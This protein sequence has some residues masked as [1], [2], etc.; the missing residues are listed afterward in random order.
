MKNLQQIL[1]ILKSWESGYI[2]PSAQMAIKD[3]IELLIKQNNDINE[4][5]GIISDLD[6]KLEE[7]KKEVNLLKES[8][9]KPS[10]NKKVNNSGELN[11]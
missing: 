7:A 3:A 6:I 2:S 4:L 5:N 10:R 9:S 11:E 8:N 1:P